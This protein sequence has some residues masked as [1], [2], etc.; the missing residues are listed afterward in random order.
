MS[1]TEQPVTPTNDSPDFKTGPDFEVAPGM[2]RHL[3]DAR[4]NGELDTGD[5][6]IN[7]GP[8]HAVAEI[9]QI[10]ENQ[11]GPIRFGHFQ[12]QLLKS[13]GV[14]VGPIHCCRG[15]PFRKI[16]ERFLS[17]RSFAHCHKVAVAQDGKQPWARCLIIA[18]GT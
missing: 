18:Q 12:K 2:Q 10:K 15:G 9:F 11:R 5:M 14:V 7:L 1:S 3:A 4:V 13:L 16:V 6:I 8:Q 17:M